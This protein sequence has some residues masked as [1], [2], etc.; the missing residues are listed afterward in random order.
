[1][2]VFFKNIFQALV[3][4]WQ[5]SRRWTIALF[6]L[7]T[8]QSALPILNLFILKRLI[9]KVTA[10]LSVAEGRDFSI[11]MT[12]IALFGLVLLL[13]S[14]VD[15]GVQL[16][17]EMQEQLVSDYMVQVIQRQS[18]NLDLAYYENPEYHN[19]FHRAQL[20]GNYRPI[21]VLKSLTGIMQNLLSL[22]LLATIFLFIHWS[23]GIFLFLLIFP[24]LYIKA[25]YS[26]KLYQWQMK[27]TELERKGYYLNTILTGSTFAKEVRLFNIGNKLMQQFKDIREQL[28][29][30][31]LYILIQRS[32]GS[33]LIVVFEVAMLVAAYATIVYQA[34]EGL[35]TVGALVM[36]FQAVQRGQSA[37]QQMVSFVGQLYQNRL[38]LNH[39]F[40]L[41][42]LKPQITSP[43]NAHPF[44]ENIQTVAFKNVNF[45]YPQ[46]TLQA[47]NNISFSAQKGQIIA[48]V[49]ENGSGKTTLIKLL[50]RLYDTTGFLNPDNSGGGI[51]LNEKDIK[52]IPLA[53]LRQKI[54][55]I[56]QDFA[57]YHFSA[58]D[59]IHISDSDRDKYIEQLVKAAQKTGAHDFI[60]TFEKGYEQ[61]LG[62]NFT[63]GVEL[64][65]GQW[66]KIALSRA[67]YKNADII[68]LDEPTSAI[69]PLAEYTI[70]EQLREDARDKI[71]IL[72]TH[73]LYNLK[74]ADNIIVMK[75]GS[76]V[77]QGNH[78]TL[79]NKKGLYW[80]MF[81]KQS[82]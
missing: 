49:G 36:Y 42:K 23:I 48:L 33:I 14:V 16:V 18:L 26:R 32:I 2:K 64:S 69:D 71:L 11:L 44:T 19:S 47:L 50:C 41:L 1:M 4:V 55:V 77:E 82:V 75:S 37:V 74:M 68:I 52:T 78:D 62:R 10:L 29:K 79:F 5:S 17:S 73:R 54:S 30:E 3:F 70:F 25:R 63:E 28:S 35:M 21:M 38:F 43:Q 24:S 15:I 65:G 8:I 46:T 59:N 72:I 9:D 12:D 27:R 53:D 57:Q 39:I 58:S 80:Q 76:V 61:M 7:M 66:Q 6:V 51:F 67:F 34:G 31:K 22:S 81:E 13:I 45:T 20:E 56:F 40:D 60:Q